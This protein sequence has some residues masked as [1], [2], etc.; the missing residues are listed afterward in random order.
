VAGVSYAR[1]RLD[2][3]FTLGTGT[4]GEGTPDTVTLSGLRV[5]AAISKAGSP[6]FSQ[7]QLRI[8]GMTE[9]QMNKLSTLGQRVSEQR[10]NTVAVQAGDDQSGMSLVFQGT[11]YEAWADFNAAPEVVFNVA[12]T[13]GMYDNIKPV[14][15]KSFRGP[16]DAAVIMAGLARDMNLTFENSGV[17]GIMLSSPYFPGTAR[18]QAEACAKAANINWLIDNNTLAIWP[19]GAARGDQVP[20]LSPGTGMRGYPTYNSTGVA[21]VALYNPSL[22]YGGKIKVQSDQTP[23]CGI[24]LVQVLDYDLEA[25]T[26]G[27]AWYCR[28]EAV[29]PRYGIAF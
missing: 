17:G 20:L 4:F 13:S 27:G 19:K 28:I 21:I 14:P 12:A 6:S 29:R 16:T 25:E 7:A 8:Y 23:A 26:P 15:A 10:K 3:T 22:T 1:R 11:I 18:R 9:S 5:S 24:W 2:V